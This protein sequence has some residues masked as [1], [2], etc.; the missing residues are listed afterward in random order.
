MNTPVVIS[1][2]ALELMSQL[3]AVAK[4]LLEAVKALKGDVEDRKLSAVK[5]SLLTMREAAGQ[6]GISYHT[7]RRYCQDGHT[8][9]RVPMPEFI[10]IGKKILFEYEVLEQWKKKDL[11]HFRTTRPRKG[12][13]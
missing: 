9:N 11:P 4:D 5:S 7:M 6:L 8:G 3:N 2:D 1:A 13:V 12:A 10:R